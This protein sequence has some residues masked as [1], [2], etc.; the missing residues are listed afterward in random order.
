MNVH[1]RE[2]E[3]ERERGEN[4]FFNIKN[5]FI[6]VFINFIISIWKLNFKIFSPLSHILTEIENSVISRIFLFSHMLSTY[7]F[8]TCQT[9][10]MSFVYLNYHLNWN[11]EMLCTFIYFSFLS[12][13]PKTIFA[14]LYT[15]NSFYLFLFIFFYF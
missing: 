14:N 8:T 2:R 12:I 10:L 7:E 13:Y 1:G 5:F 9:I 3:W 4:L 15:K 11:T 6:A